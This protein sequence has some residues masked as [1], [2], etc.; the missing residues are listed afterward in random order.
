MGTR[1]KRGYNKAAARVNSLCI[2]VCTVCA[3]MNWDK[4]YYYALVCNQLIHYVNH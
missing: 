4:E 1:G 2:N 3:I